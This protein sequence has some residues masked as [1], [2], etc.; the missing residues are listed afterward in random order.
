MRPVN[1]A[2]GRAF[3]QNEDDTWLQKPFQK[4]SVWWFVFLE[5]LF[6][7]SKHQ[8]RISSMNLFWYCVGI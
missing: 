3:G 2:E 4:L 8:N 1:P 5:A 6:S 7:S